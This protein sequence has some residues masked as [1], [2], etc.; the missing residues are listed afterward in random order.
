MFSYSSYLK[1]PWYIQY[2]DD[3]CHLIVVSTISPQKQE[4]SDIWYC[5]YTFCALSQ[6]ATEGIYHSTLPKRAKPK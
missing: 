1:V 3:S 6:M 4:Y 5:S 2:F